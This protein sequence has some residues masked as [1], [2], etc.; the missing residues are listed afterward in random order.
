[1]TKVL[2]DPV[3]TGRV[4]TC[5]TSYLVWEIMKDLCQKRSDMFFYLLIPEKLDDDEDMFLKEQI[6]GLEDRIRFYPYPYVKSDRME[7]LFKFSDELR[8]YVAPGNTPVWDW[9]FVLTSRIPQIPQF[10]VNS[11]RSVA[12]DHGSYRGIIGL[13]EMPM[14]SFRKTVSWANTGHLDP[15]TMAAYGMSNGVVVNNLWTK[16]LASRA[17]RKS[18]TPSEVMKFQGQMHEAVPVSME[19]LNLRDID[20]GD[21][22]NV[23]FSGRPTGT[24]NFKEI[25]ELFRKHFSYPLDKGRELKFIVSTQ[26][27]ST[28]STKVGEIDF[29]EFQYND[30][31]KFYK[32]LKEE[33]HL[34]VNLSTVEDFS[35][36][37]YEPLLHGVPVLVADRDWCGFLGDDYPF[38]TKNFVSSYAWVK[39]FAEDY[40]G[41]Y[42][43]FREW[44]ETTWR[45]FTES[46]R[47]VTTSTQV[48]SL[49]HGHEEKAVSHI[50][51]TGVGKSYQAVVE[52]A[53]ATDLKE[54][55]LLEF[56]K[57]EGLITDHEDWNGIPMAKRPNIYL[58]KVFMV[59]A[60]WDETVV[61]GVYTRT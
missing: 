41:C 46:P 55:N 25:A 52:A 32:M 33:A 18:M 38:K 11:G 8:E 51:D 57:S 35:L 1:M 36:S 19:R 6:K 39:Q 42:Q 29:V 20:P 21:T 23:V 2:V 5:S 45:G 10:R 17:A 4:S 59:L 3:Y 54:I 12:Y 14:F 26:A 15:M 13:D 43:K 37:T 31:D 56:A 49:I 30:R 24:R 48:E 16:D 61:P 44:E 53:T 60:G 47:N 9:D 22:L 7:E 50:I 27:Q 28:G 58:M 40:E 34:V